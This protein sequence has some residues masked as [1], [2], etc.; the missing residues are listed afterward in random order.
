VFRRITRADFRT[1]LWIVMALALAWRVGYVLVTKRHAVVWGDSFSYHYGANLLAEGKGFID[2]LR[3]NFAGLSFPS[4]YHPPLYMV[5][6]AAWSVV[7]LKGAL[8][9]RLVSCLLGAATVGLIGLLGR[10]LAGERAG[11]IAA[12][13][14]AAYPHLWLND[15]S[16]LSETAA[17]F[18]VVLAMLT[19]ERFREQPT[20]ARTWELGFALALAVLGRAELA[21]L[22]PVIALPLVLRTRGLELGDRFMRIGVVAA[23]SLILLGPWVGYNMVRFEKPVYLSN[24]FG[25][26]LLGGSCDATFHGPLIGY[27]TYCPGPSTAA[28]LPPPPASTRARWDR[29]P[30]SARTRAEEKAYF[31]RYFDGA[32]DESENDVTARKEAMKYIRANESQIPLVVAARIGRVWNVYR[33][34][35]NATLDGLVE[36]RGLAQARVALVAFYLYAAAAIVGLVALR[37][38]RHPIWPYLVLVAVVTFTAAISFAVQR[39]RIPVDAVLPAL[40]AVGVDALW[41]ARSQRG[42]DAT[43]TSELV[44]TTAPLS[45]DASRR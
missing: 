1:K 7:G 4:A 32:P 34:W 38:R 39:Y 24:G 15:A 23:A 16:L 12:I 10:R 2:P 5:Y 17:A 19:I 45:T 20:M 28:R 44:S 35:Q 25:A 26:T 13:L 6:L 30:N 18:A 21:I 14:A 29:D 3:Y 41:R 40:A 31:R 9:H 27:W 36:G 43:V 33:P 42:E 37:K 22:V 11:I 8:A